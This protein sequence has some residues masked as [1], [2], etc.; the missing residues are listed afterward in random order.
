MQKVDGVQTVQVSLKDGLVILDLKAEN[1][2]TLA[3]LRQ[4]IKNNGFVSKEADA[5]ARGTP[6]R[7]DTFEV[8]LT[9]ERLAT[10]SQRV[11]SGDEW[12]VKVKAP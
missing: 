12:S 6:G 1:T 7:G 8:S 2:V 5:I 9:H 11:V 10:A 3:A 4:T